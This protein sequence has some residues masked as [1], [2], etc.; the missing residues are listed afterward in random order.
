MTDIIFHFCHITRTYNALNLKI[1]DLLSMFNMG[2]QNLAISR[3]TLL[4]LDAC[5]FFAGLEQ[6]LKILLYVVNSEKQAFN[7][8][9]E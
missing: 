9:R 2:L 3:V 4:L 1:D 6:R 5:F 8:H 7:A